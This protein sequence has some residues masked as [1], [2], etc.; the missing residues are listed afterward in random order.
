[1]ETRGDAYF[2]RGINKMDIVKSA[3]AVLN[4][5]DKENDNRVLF[6]FRDLIGL[7]LMTTPKV[8][9]F[10]VRF[11]FL[12]L[13]FTGNRIMPTNSLNLL[14]ELAAWSSGIVSA[15]HRGDWSYRS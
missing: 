3:R 13:K 6:A 10:G 1:V 4:E 11:T 9:F 14:N 8:A 7:L 15:C 2:W 5:G 12:N